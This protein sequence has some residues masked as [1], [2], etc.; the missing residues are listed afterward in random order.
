MWNPNGPP[1]FT[2][3]KIVSNSPVR[4]SLERRLDS[5]L[6]LQFKRHE[7]TAERSPDV[8]LARYI[9]GR[10]TSPDIAFQQ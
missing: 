10:P 2:T 8:V 1:H 4:L 6:V 9:S 5:K 7:L 3:K